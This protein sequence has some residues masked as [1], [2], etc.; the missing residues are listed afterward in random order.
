MEI[1]GATL[2]F[3]TTPANRQ[4]VRLMVSE[5]IL[6]MKDLLASLDQIQSSQKM[7][8]ELL[9]GLFSGIRP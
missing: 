4:L 8:T 2:E 9:S 3:A 7:G 6:V 1:R 5:E